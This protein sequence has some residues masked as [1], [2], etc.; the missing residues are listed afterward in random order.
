[1]DDREEIKQRYEKMCSAMIKKYTS[2]VSVKDA[3]LVFYRISNKAHF[4]NCSKIWHL[5][6]RK[7]I[8]THENQPLNKKYLP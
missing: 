1:M 4:F 8:L 5:N 7:E 2:A 3:A 6:I